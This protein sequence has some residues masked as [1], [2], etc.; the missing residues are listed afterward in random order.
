MSTSCAACARALPDLRALRDAFGENEL[1]LVGV[2]V[3]SADSVQALREYARKQQLP[4][5]LQLGRPE[6]TVRQVREIVA[7]RLHANG[8]TTPACIVTDPSGSI[9][10]ARWGAP[11]LSE[12]RRLQAAQGD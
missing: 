11:T 6:E 3:D 1:T 12:L 10:T 8:S 7:A 2:P 5:T 9:L 4:Y